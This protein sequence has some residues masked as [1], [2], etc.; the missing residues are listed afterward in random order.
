MDWTI[1][2]TSFEDFAEHNGIST[3]IVEKYKEQY[4]WDM[5]MLEAYLEDVYGKGT[6]VITSDSLS[7]VL[8]ILKTN[9]EDPVRRLKEANDYL[10]W[11]IQQKIEKGEKKEE[12]I[13]LYDNLKELLK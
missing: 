6:Y 1:N 2:Y 12:W 9:E 10:L 5:D 11:C 3:E 8:I 13:K 7:D 4:E